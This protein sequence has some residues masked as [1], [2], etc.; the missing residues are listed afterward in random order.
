MATSLTV[1]ASGSSGNAALV[2]SGDFGLLIDAGV[3]PR[4]LVRRLAVAGFG[5]NHINAVV[6]THTHGD[7]WS[8]R[9]LAQLNHRRLP[10][11]CHDS[12]IEHLTRA[13]QAFGMLRADKLVQPFSAGRSFSAGGGVRMAPF[14]V[15]HDSHRT[16][17]FRI[18]CDEDGAAIGY[19]AD[20]GGFC[21][22]I[23]EMLTGVD[24]LALEFNHDEAMLKNSGRPEYLIERILGPSGHLSNR[25]AVELLLQVLADDC[26]TKPSSVIAL[27]LSRECN[28]PE[29]ADKELR[30]GLQR[31]GHAA[32]VVLAEQSRAAPT[33]VVRES[34]PH[35]G[36][37]PSAMAGRT[38]PG[39]WDEPSPA[40]R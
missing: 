32:R 15:A 5:W 6:L 22:R 31:A 35:N 16:F 39:F 3:G 18:E 40:G 17:G 2:R 23:V 19:A 36:H 12:H 24:A 38:T 30:A 28:R 29:I 25:Q 1:L 27:H 4:T 7:H 37:G 13:S 8:E 9:T 33:I 14:E 21:G 34:G 26:A 10:V 11:H 20:L